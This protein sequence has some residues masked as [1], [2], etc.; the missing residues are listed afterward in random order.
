MSKDIQ[1]INDKLDSLHHRMT[2]FYAWAAILQKEFRDIQQRQKF[3]ESQCD[4]DFTSPSQSRL[5]ERLDRIK[6]T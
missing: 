1:D 6:E 4:L 5:Q 3:I 2:R